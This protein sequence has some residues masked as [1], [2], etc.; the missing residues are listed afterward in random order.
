M[1][2]TA[3][4]LSTAVPIIDSDGRIIALLAGRPDDV[5]WISLQNRA[6]QILEEQR[7]RCHFPKEAQKNRRG[8]FPALP[9]GIS[10]G[11]GQRHPKNLSQNASNSRVLAYLNA[12]VEFQ[13]IAGFTSSRFMNSLQC[14]AFAHTL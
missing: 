7:D 3:T 2:K 12:Q 1:N 14:P 9:V 8:R 10:F 5:G 4:F 11:G 6:A 13:R